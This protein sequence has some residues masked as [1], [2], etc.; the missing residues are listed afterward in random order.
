MTE[1]NTATDRGGLEVLAQAECLSLLAS[2][3]VGRV[4]FVEG[5]EPVIL[6][7]NHIVDGRTVAFRTTYGSKLDIAW[8]EKAAAFEADDFD[9]ETRTGWSVV[10]RGTAYEVIDDAEVTELNASDLEPWTDLGDRTRWVRI[11][12]NQITGRRIVRF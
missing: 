2:V 8:R 1:A 10:L 11:V 4:G 6:P 7:V 12:P 3:E 9:P 5:G